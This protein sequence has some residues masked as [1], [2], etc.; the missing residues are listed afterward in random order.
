MHIVSQ[1]QSLTVG[2]MRAK[3][4]AA[5]FGIGES[6]WWGWCAEGRVPPGIKLGPRVTVWRISDV[7]EFMEQA[8]SEGRQ[9]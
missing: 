3:A 8:A 9:Q 5:Y 2:A 4:C 6:T 1:V 7:V